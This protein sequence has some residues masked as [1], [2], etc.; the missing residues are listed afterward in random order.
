MRGPGR[1]FQKGKS[2]NPSGRPK[3]PEAIEAK[4]IVADVKE[5]A[6]ELTPQA[7]ETLQ[8]IMNDPKAPPAAR[9]GAAVAVLDRGWGRPQQ[10]VSVTSTLDVAD[11]IINRWKKNLAR[12]NAEE[13]KLIEGEARR[14]NA[15]A[16]H[17][18]SRLGEPAQGR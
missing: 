18:P 16:E 11:R 17:S 7:L 3:R 2:G 12:L 13:P 10:D 8:T 15:S 14:L 1:P 5:A 9:V 6:R 4:R